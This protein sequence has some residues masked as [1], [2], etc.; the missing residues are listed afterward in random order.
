MTSVF[1]TGIFD[2]LHPGHVAFLQ[3]AAQYGDLIVA[4]GSDRTLS[5]LRGRR[6][7]NTEQERCR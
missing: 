3:Q 4:V 7:A 5:E 1:A 2:Q 6:P